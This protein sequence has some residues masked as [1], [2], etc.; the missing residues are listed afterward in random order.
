MTG[1]LK[2]LGSCA[3]VPLVPR[4]VV[5]HDPED[6]ERRLDERLSRE[7]KE[8]RTEAIER[9]IRAAGVDAINR[10]A[11]L[12]SVYG[13]QRTGITAV[14]DGWKAGSVSGIGFYGKP[15][16]GKTWA[17]A[18]TLRGFVERRYDHLAETGP[19]YGPWPIWINW[20]R[21]LSN[22]RNLLRDGGPAY[23]N[24]IDQLCECPLLVIDDL[25][26]ERTGEDTWSREVFYEILDGRQSNK[27][28]IV[29]TSNHDPE[30]LAR[31]YRERIMSRLR[32]CAPPLTLAGKDRRQ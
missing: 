30:E 4:P 22:L 28:R 2:T 14:L 7:A 11:T 25:G 9:I 20:S 10:P 18:A 3:V 6:W 27:K 26:V 32:S 1:D 16:T 19:I 17:A 5:R 8:N 21:E 23:A 31:R 12:E 13:L 15:G 24:R 29:W